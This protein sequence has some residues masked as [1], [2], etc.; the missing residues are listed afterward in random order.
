M[1]AENSCKDIHRFD[2]KL[3]RVISVARSLGTYRNKINNAM[4]MLNETE[5]WHTL[6][7]GQ[8]LSKL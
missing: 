8:E 3:K 4:I 6:T 1:N 7:K 2:A 5:T